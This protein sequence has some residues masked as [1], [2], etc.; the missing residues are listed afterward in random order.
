[1]EAPSEYLD[2]SRV[3]QWMLHTARTAGIL[4][5]G[6]KCTPECLNRSNRGVAV[7]VHL[8]RH[9]ITNDYR[10]VWKYSKPT[11]EERV[12]Y[13]IVKKF[14]C[15]FACQQ[16]HFHHCSATTCDSVERDMCKRNEQGNL[17]C[18]YSHNVVQVQ[19]SHNWKE[20][21]K[22]CH[23]GR[24]MRHTDPGIHGF[25]NHA[26]CN[27]HDKAMVRSARLVVFHCMFSPLRTEIHKNQQL[28]LQRAVINKVQQYSKTCRRNQKFI[29]LA[30]FRRISIREGYFSS[31]TYNTVLAS[32]DQET[33]LRT[34]APMV[35]SLF[36]II[37]EMCDGTFKTF[38]MFACSILYLMIEGISVQGCEIIYK[39]K[40]MRILLP[41]PVETEGLFRSM[42]QVINKLY[43]SSSS[44]LQ[45]QRNFLTKIQKQIQATL[46]K[47]VNTLECALAF[48]AK[49]DQ[50]TVMLRKRYYDVVAAE[51]D[52]L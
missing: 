49:I 50:N 21:K 43:P 23:N 52:G 22:G 42:S 35:V 47:N 13:E 45:P 27:V 32:H 4:H 31:C 5:A 16:L 28:C 9:K 3:F 11:T 33:T 1:M 30:E 10:W 36:K 48:K 38:P 44:L 24:G 51:S 6:D 34:L 15:F 17:L 14:S 18:L 46:R 39:M 41:H 8:W 19:E 29:S 40:Y 37:N 12:N 2:T 25:P 7:P 26:R 20:A